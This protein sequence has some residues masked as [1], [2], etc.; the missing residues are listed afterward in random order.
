MEKFS[1]HSGELEL[2]LE[3]FESSKFNIL[4]GQSLDSMLTMAFET[5]ERR[6]GGT[7]PF[8]IFFLIF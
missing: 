1:I 6:K 4:D 2:I 8:L 5:G 3:P 7:F